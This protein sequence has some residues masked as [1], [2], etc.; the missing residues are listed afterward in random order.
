MKKI[1]I[2][3]I[4]VLFAFTIFAADATTAAKTSVKKATVAVEAAVA[5]VV[6]PEPTPTPF[7]FMAK[8]KRKIKA[9]FGIKPAATP[10]PVSATAAPV[11]TTAVPATPAKK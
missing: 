9:I 6:A 2:T 11:T 8:V 10:V 7:S 3:L 1:I 4:A 5:T